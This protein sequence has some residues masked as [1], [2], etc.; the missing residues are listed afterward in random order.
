MTIEEKRD[1]VIKGYNPG[2]PEDVRKYINGIPKDYGY[3][4]ENL[5]GADQKTEVL[6]EDGKILEVVNENIYADVK[7][8]GM[9]NNSSIKSN[10]SKKI[11]ESEDPFASVLP[12]KKSNKETGYKDGV[13]YLLAFIKG[14]KTGERREAL[15]KLNDVIKKKKVLGNT[16]EEGLREAELKLLKKFNG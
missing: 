7:R 16:Y 6:D 10:P 11:I 9:L 5:G 3:E 12:S 14:M 8:R 15:I 2:N 1:M 4:E 13:E